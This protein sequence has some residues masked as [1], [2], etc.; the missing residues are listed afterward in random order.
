VND[1]A[2]N[3][4][5]SRAAPSGGR[6]SETKHGFVLP[7]GECDR[8]AALVNRL[9][10]AAV[11]ASDNGERIE[12]LSAALRADAQLT[13]V[14]QRMSGRATDAP[15]GCEELAAWLARQIPSRFDG[16]NR[17]TPTSLFCRALLAELTRLRALEADFARRLEHEKLVAMYHLAYGAS[18]EINNPL[19]NIATRA[20]MLLRDEADPEKRRRLA[21]MNAQAFR[22]F[23]MIAD[24]MLFAKPPQP[25]LAPVDLVKVVRAVLGE[26]EPAAREQGTTLQSIGQVASLTLAADATQLAAAVRAITQNAL[27]ALATGGEIA[28]D[29]RRDAAAECAEIVVADTGPGLSDEARAH[30]FDPFYSGREAGRGLGLGLSKS[31]RIVQLHGGRIEVVSELGRGTTLVIVLP[32]VPP[33]GN[34]ADAEPGA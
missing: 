19:A 14:V 17:E 6:S 30:L 24:L 26:L 10:A 5:R 11:L 8:G 31:W 12:K 32:L 23:E 34:A 3:G 33:A 7:D 4:G 18:H 20:Q 21:T 27:E 9:L 28:I 15:A 22:A 29:V 25:V 13:A 1:A 2:V 16:P